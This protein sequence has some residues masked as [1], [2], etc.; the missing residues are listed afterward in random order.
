MSNLSPVVTQ[1][2]FLLSPL[3]TSDLPASH[4]PA[5]PAANTEPTASD[6]EEGPSSAL[7]QALADKQ[8]L[9]TL[10]QKLKETAT[11]LGVNATPQAILSALK[12][13]PMD[14][15]PASANTSVTL[16]AFITGSGLAVPNSHFALTALADAVLN[17]AQE[18]PLGN[19]GG[20][21]SW[22]LPPSADA[23][24]RLLEATRHYGADHPN[25]PDMTLS[26]GV[27]E[28]LNSNQP[29]S[30]EAANDP[31]KALESLVSTPRSQAL[32]QTLQTHMNGIATDTSVNDYTLAAINLILDPQALTDPKATQVAGFDLA[33]KAHWGKPVSGIREG[34]VA[35]LTAQHQATPGMANIGAYLLL[36]RKAPELL[37][38]DIPDN[39]TYGSPAW[40]SLS[41]AAAA[42]EAQS[43]GKVPNM[44]FAQVMMEAESATLN[45]RAITQ[46]AQSAA[47]R[48]WGAV[49]GVLSEEEADRYNPSDREKA[50]NAFNQ[51]ASERLEASSQIHAEIPSRKA[52]ALAKLKER[53]GDTLPFEEK[54]LTVNDTT[55]PFTRA[56]YSRNRGPAGRHSLLDI[57]MSGLHQYKWQSTDQRI[58]DATRGHSL[59]FNVNRVFNTQFTQAIDHRKKGIGVA[60]KQ[61]IAQLPL[62]DRQ[63]LEHGKLE[64]YQHN[65][66]I[67]GMGFTGRTLEE[68]NEKLLVKATGVNDE[69][70][71]EIDLRRGCIKTVPN[72]VLTRKHERDANRDYPIEPFTPTQT[73]AAKFDQDK[74]IPHPL[75]TPNSFSSARTQSIVDAFV[76]HLDID[77]KDVV[78]QAKGTSSYDQQM[79]QEHKLADFFLD[80]I[81]LRSAIVN[82]RQGNYAEGAVD[83][84]LDIFGFV[85]AGAGTV[86][87][88]AKVGAK[89]VST[90]TK[91]LKV[92][93]ILGTTAINEFNPLNGLGDLVKGGTRL[94]DRGVQKI[95]GVAH[96]PYGEVTVGTF[97]S[98]ERTVEGSTIVSNGQRYAYDPV[99]MKPYGSPLEDFNPLDTLA[100]GGSTLTHSPRQQR[101]HRY[102]PM[103]TGARPIR[104]RQ[105]LPDG[106]YAESLKGK[107]EPDHFKP[108]TKA[109]TLNK[110]N[111][112]M[113]NYYDA[114]QETG[115]PPRPSIP[116]VPKPIPAAE[117]LTETLN[118]SPGV[119]LGE[120]HKQMASFKVLFDNVETLK[121]QNVKKVYF[122]GLIDMPQG[123]VDDGIGILGQSR[124]PRQNPS[125]PELRKKLEDNGIEVMPLD[126]YYL[127]RH[128]DVRTPQV[129]TSAGNGSVQ[130]LK[131]FNYYAAETIQANSGTE[132]WVALVGSSHMNT[133][134]GV[135]GLAELTGSLG[136]GVTDNH[137][138]TGQLGLKARGAVP[139]PNKPLGRN[140]VAGDLQIFVQA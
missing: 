23:Q 4:L 129:P 48:V 21:L 51:Q 103:G 30:T 35:H 73:S 83:L 113:N 138:I 92:A 71:Y 33:R 10:G 136:I 105:P 74:E 64:F 47:L 107:L 16:E 25:P 26:L 91:A 110:F 60:V 89:A 118:V 95:K 36:A 70:V 7:E 68:K 130:R 87:K 13:T 41:I 80:L 100:P 133:T 3:P 2:P 123:L 120:S 44:S 28:Y 82:F 40:V 125:F 11:R 15:L 139:D 53:F 106:D 46:Q 66:Y 62:A 140:D 31:A 49:N 43:P 114:I 99:Q 122:E 67:L 19:F 65:T 137:K 108:D 132:K 128:K 37:I 77:N 58:V 63:K 34:L 39:V 27:L 17:R 54:L 57:A 78:K 79:E 134:E 5:Q 32:G 59:E 14:R 94:I 116:S 29:L 38:K 101:G 55:Q 90:T 52:I 85:T 121:R 88:V 18:H 109:A 42:I 131:E 1:Q 124:I 111:N 102:T 84:G 117:L 8:N 98:A 6:T 104:V 97:K 76:E 127:T 72:Q 24:R 93:K 81:P 119:V 12:S 112:E 115:I 75:P 9:R 86:A 135:P 69:T 61:M 20:A 96:S 22:P 56:L 126:H 45:E 50:R